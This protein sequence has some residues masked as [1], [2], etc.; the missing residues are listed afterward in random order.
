M[1]PVIDA[2]DLYKCYPGFAPVLKGASIQVEAGEMAAI[3]GPSGCGKSTM[4]HIIGMLH[5]PDSGSLQILD[6]DVLALNREQTAEFRRENM[7]FVMQA[8]NLF[9]HSTVFENVEFPLIYDNIP[10][11]ERWER[12][13]RALDLVRLSRRVHYRSN[14]LSGG[15]QQR[16]A[17]ARAMVN[18]PRILL[19]DEPTGALDARTSRLIMENF[20]KLC[21]EGGVAM[22][23]VTHDPKMAEFCDSIYTLEDGQL[24]CQKHEPTP[25]SASS[26]R[27]ILNAPEPVVRGAMITGLFPSG[28]EQFFIRLAARLYEADLLSRIYSLRSEPL[29]TGQQNYSLPLA[30]RYIG[31]WKKLG[32][33]IAFLFHTP[34]SAGLWQLWRKMTTGS[35]YGFFNKLGAF[36]CGKILTLWSRQEYV[37]FF[38]AGSA[39]EQALSAWICAK[40]LGRP[41]AFSVDAQALPHF[42]PFWELLVSEAAFVSCTDLSVLNALERLLPK[43][44]KDKFLLLRPVP[45]IL[46]EEE[47]G[48]ASSDPKRE[49]RLEILCMGPDVS[50]HGYRLMMEM[51]QYLARMKVNFHLTV[52]G[53]LSFWQRLK[54]RRKDFKG[55]VSCFASEIESGLIELYRNADLFIAYP[56]SYKGAEM[57]LPDYVCSAMAFGLCVIAV[58]MTPGMAELLD[59][60]KNSILLPSAKAITIAETIGHLAE[61]T[62]RLKELGEAAKEAFKSLMDFTGEMKLVADRMTMASALADRSLAEKSS[63]Q[64]RTN[65]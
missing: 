64:E 52:L 28:R 42:F 31:F 25:F 5:A 1:P 18:N 6:T 30:V 44:P 23:M 14:Q 33:C 53:K 40:T 9:E 21:H 10:A 45:P 15:E 58:D 63:G 57:A 27:S 36:A 39:G 38:Y 16:V 65:D 43:V 34:S 17:I 12:V 11:Q 59:P 49:K 62:E 13:I 7:G 50:R 4:L 54:I 19:A 51:A 60:G 56:P 41:Y 32:A 55:C 35:R 3:M 46:P 26:G 8:S 47:G 22:I 2:R 61:K 48:E 20:R 24:R 37:E 29:K